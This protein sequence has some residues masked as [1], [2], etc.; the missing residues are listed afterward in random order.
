[1]PNWTRVPISS[2]LD[3]CTTRGFVLIHT[4]QVQLRWPQIH[5]GNHFVWL[6]H[7]W[8]DSGATVSVAA[9][10]M[11]LW[12]F[13]GC[14]TCRPSLRAQVSSR[15][16]VLLSTV[17]CADSHNQDPGHSNL[18][19]SLLLISAFDVAHKRYRCASAN[20]SQSLR[21]KQRRDT[22]RDQS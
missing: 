13:R 20:N 14:W 4:K 1:M 22:R 11:P 10:G 3:E 17:V 12:R 15:R 5:R 2:H 19:I 8:K 7:G 21:I 16:R 6:A 18:K 9:V